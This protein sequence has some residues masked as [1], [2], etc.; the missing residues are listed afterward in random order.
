MSEYTKPVLNVGDIIFGTDP[1]NDFDGMLLIVTAVDPPKKGDKS[2]YWYTLLTEEGHEDYV[3]DVDLT[4]WKY[5]KRTADLDLIRKNHFPNFVTQEPA[6][7][8]RFAGGQIFLGGDKRTADRWTHYFVETATLGGPRTTQ[9]LR[10]R[11]EDGSIILIDS[12]EVREHW[13]YIFAKDEHRKQAI[14]DTY[15][16]SVGATTSRP[17]VAARVDTSHLRKSLEE[18]RE[19]SAK[20]REKIHAK[21]KAGKEVENKVETVELVG[22][23]DNLL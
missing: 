6:A 9:K 7:P 19:K 21:L 10:L 2:G 16:T 1:G 5:T 4:F 3:N 17:A 15:F 11:N 23:L 12:K 22:R 14:K 18:K 8:V 20:L 13:S